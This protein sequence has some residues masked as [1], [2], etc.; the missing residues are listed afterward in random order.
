MSIPSFSNKINGLKALENLALGLGYIV[1]SNQQT[2][3]SVNFSGN[4]LIAIYITRP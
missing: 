2:V 4:D 1:Y 3:K